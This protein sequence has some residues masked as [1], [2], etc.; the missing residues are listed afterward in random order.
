MNLHFFVAAIV[1]FLSS[2]P[3]LSSFHLEYLLKLEKGFL[4]ETMAFKKNLS[5]DLVFKV[6]S[7]LADYGFHI[8]NWYFHKNEAGVL[9]AVSVYEVTSFMH[10][11]TL[12]KDDSMLYTLHFTN[13]KQMQST[14]KKYYSLS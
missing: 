11:K 9:T 4:L 13:Y 12:H 10:Y 6:I 3:G 2:R 1:H 7:F 14:F 5:G 8:G